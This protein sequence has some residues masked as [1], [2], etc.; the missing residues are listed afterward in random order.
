MQDIPSLAPIANVSAEAVFSQLDRLEQLFD[1]LDADAAKQ[2]Y[3]HGQDNDPRTSSAQ[4]PLTNT[5]EYSS[6]VYAP[7]SQPVLS[8]RHSD[9]QLLQKQQQQSYRQPIFVSGRGQALDVV[10]LSRPETENGSLLI[11]S[12]REAEVQLG[13]L[14]RQTKTALQVGVILLTHHPTVLVSQCTQIGP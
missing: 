3:P 7:Q 8:S 12:L 14:R 1:R 5:S 2:T 10:P 4:M 6:A 9:A 13:E 11:R